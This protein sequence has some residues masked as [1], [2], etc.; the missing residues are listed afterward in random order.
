MASDLSTRPRGLRSLPRRQIVISFIGILVAIFLSSLDQTVV[1]TAMP[2]IIADLGGFSHY[3]WV[4]TAYIIASAV[5]I[6]MTGRLTDIFGR[7]IFF[8][9][10]LSIFLFFSIACGL[11]RTMAQLIISRGLQGIGGGIM[12]AN[13]FTAV[14][15]LFPPG[16]R[17]K[18]VGFISA[19]FGISSIV[20]PILG[21][22]VTDALSWHWVFF[23]NL[24]LGIVALI[25]FI[26]FFPNIRPDDD[27]HIVD[28]GGIV[29]MI[30]AILPAMLALSWGGVQ[31]PWQSIQILG[32][33]GIAAVSVAAFI[34]IERRC[35]EP[36]VPLTLFNN[37]IVTVSW[38]VALLI[39]FAMFGSIIFVPLFFQGVMGMT[40]T[41][42]GSFL[43]PMMLGMVCGSFISGQMLSRM[44]GHYKIHGIAGIALMGLGMALLMNMSMETGYTQAVINII[45]MGF[46]LGLTMPLYTIAVQNAVPYSLLGV[47]TSLTTFSRSLGGSIGLAVLGTVMHKRMVSGIA[48]ALPA[49]VK[50]VLPARQIA[51]LAE[52]PQLLVDPEGQQQLRAV[53]E[54]LDVHGRGLYEALMLGLR[55]ALADALSRAF[56]VALIVLLV[57]F[58]VNLFL[59][60]L[61]L[62][63]SH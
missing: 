28:Y 8:L 47:G 39:G 46:G 45:T 26:K 61:P 9:I 2:R 44:G 36:I 4:A 32:L 62:K 21:G 12:M 22:F 35:P 42:S 41:A 50:D 1:G 48:G 63:R 40:A 37:K 14:G 49:S 56:L 33:F 24:P 6:P 51:S 59:K 38:I 52:N 17:G 10:G 43:T 25:L 29:T 5:A 60:E 57:A 23:L 53:I 55:H 15:D 16:E 30:L 7:K 34:L 27:K 3:T 58:A 11:S 18:Y 54:R 13:T 19:V 31:F 20:G